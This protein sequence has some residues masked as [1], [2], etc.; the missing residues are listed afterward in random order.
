MNFTEQFLAA[1]AAAKDAK[2]NCVSHVMALAHLS[3]R[4]DGDYP[5][6]IAAVAKISTAAIT[7]VLDVLE[8]L[9]LVERVRTAED[10][11]SYKVYLTPKGRETLK[12]MLP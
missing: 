10:R 12:L 11:R 5:T 1:C 4:A 7:G 6:R 9:Q 2:L 3:Q 8:K